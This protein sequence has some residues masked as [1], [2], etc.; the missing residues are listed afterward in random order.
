MR[1]ARGVGKKIG[2]LLRDG[3]EL[4]AKCQRQTR[5]DSDPMMIM[6]PDLKTKMVLLGLVLRMITAGNRFL[7]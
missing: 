2:N 6:R 3:R 7:L 5:R 1:A 4:R